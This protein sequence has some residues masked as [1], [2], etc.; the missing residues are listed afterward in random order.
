MRQP[1]KSKVTKKVGG[2][3]ISRICEGARYSSP[4]RTEKKKKSNQT[5]VFRAWGRLSHDLLRAAKKRSKKGARSE[6]DD[7]TLL[8]AS[9]RKGTRKE[10][11]ENTA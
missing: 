4:E 2:K 6:K 10:V 11:L 1:D 9:S 3:M 7:R 8:Q 5:P